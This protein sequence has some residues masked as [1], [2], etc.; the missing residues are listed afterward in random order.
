V[1]AQPGQI[2]QHGRFMFGATAALVNILDPQQKP[3]PQTL[4]RGET[5]QRGKPVSHMQP[6]RGAGGKS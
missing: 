6:A 1:Q 4:G 2:R 5:V 3:P